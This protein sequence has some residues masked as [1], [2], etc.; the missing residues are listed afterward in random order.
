MMTTSRKSIT[1]AAWYRVVRAMSSVAVNVLLVLNVILDVLALFI[2]VF[3][4]THNPKLVTGVFDFLRE[5]GLGP[6]FLS[7]MT[8]WASA[9]LPAAILGVLSAVD[10]LFVPYGILAKRKSSP[11]VYRHFTIFRGAYMVILATGDILLG[12]AAKTRSSD[13]DRT[14]VGVHIVYL[15]LIFV[16]LLVYLFDTRPPS[17]DDLTSPPST[18]VVT[19]LGRPVATIPTLPGCDPLLPPTASR[20]LQMF[21]KRNLSSASAVGWSGSQATLV[22]FVPSSGTRPGSPAPCG[23]AVSPAAA[24]GTA[25]VILARSASMYIPVR[26]ASPMGG[27]GFADAGGPL[28]ARSS[29]MYVRPASP[30][31]A[32]APS[33][34]ERSPMSTGGSVVFAPS[35]VSR[36]LSPMA[37]APQ[38]MDVPVRPESPM[39]PGPHAYVSQSASPMGPVPHAYVPVRPESL[40]GPAPVTYALVRPESP[41]GPAPVA[42]APVRPE[43]PMTT[44]GSVVF[45][46]NARPESSLEPAP[47]AYAPVRPESPMGGPAPIAGRASAEIPLLA[48]GASLSVAAGSQ[49]AW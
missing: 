2:L 27:M 48:R 12:N 46:P 31:V 4:V 43:S 1:D 25:P 17:Y 37:S 7:I 11:V 45:A 33:H 26:P 20:P 49:P 34:A 5:V 8:L 40:T 3:K 22:T 18:P 29:S 6:W 14:H 28:V 36:P 16:L 38:N 30:M 35:A 44:G 19:T 47:P 32:F 9:S 21:L 39:G 24:I 41:M 42:C 10:I 23:A 15:A 13:Q